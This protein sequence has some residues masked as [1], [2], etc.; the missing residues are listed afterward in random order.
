MLVEIIWRV[1]SWC[2]SMGN[3]S[4]QKELWS[5]DQWPVVIVPSACDDTDLLLLP[6]RPRCAQ[7]QKD[8]EGAGRGHD[9]PRANSLR[10]IIVC[11]FVIYLMKIL[12]Q[13]Y[14]IKNR[15]KKNNWW[16][17]TKQRKTWGLFEF[18]KKRTSRDQQETE[19]DFQTRKLLKLLTTTLKGNPDLK[20]VFTN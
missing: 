17:K 2:D 20:Y 12:R 16:L 4:R 3:P 1:N 9:S 8:K 15:V 6:W 14:R 18:S 7:L 13:S 19:R 5:G 10:F 11:W